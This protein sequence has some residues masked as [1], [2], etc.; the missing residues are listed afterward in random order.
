MIQCKVEGVLFVKTAK[1]TVCKYIFGLR[2]LNYI[3]SSN[4]NLVLF[5]QREIGTRTS[6]TEKVF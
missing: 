3:V 2:R 6:H 4:F 1:L 5:T